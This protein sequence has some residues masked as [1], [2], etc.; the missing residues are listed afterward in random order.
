M[1]D[2]SSSSSSSRTHWRIVTYIL[3]FARSA[4]E[5]IESA[6]AKRIEYGL[7]FRTTYFTL[8]NVRMKF[9]WKQ[10]WCRF[11]ICPQSWV[12]L[13]NDNFISHSFH[14]FYKKKKKKY[15]KIWW[16]YQ[17]LFELDRA[18]KIIDF[19]STRKHP[20]N[21][22]RL[23]LFIRFYK[24]FLEKQINQLYELSVA[25]WLNRSIGQPKKEL[26]MQFFFS[27][28]SQ[29]QTKSA[30]VSLCSKPLKFELRIEF[31]ILETSSN[32]SV[33]ALFSCNDT[34]SESVNEYKH[35]T[36]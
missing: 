32:L 15:F 16:K 23:L 31:N 10:N 28:L 18:N 21:G 2:S 30:F 12:S 7:V 5:Y 20:S 13:F 17:R 8:R 25:F 22:K 35:K 33:C 6:N 4:S 26:W 9:K 3:S 27:P 1:N 34:I 24:I 11:V 36:I 14:F 29:L 19:H